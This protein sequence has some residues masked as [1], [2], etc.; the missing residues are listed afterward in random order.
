MGRRKRNGERRGYAS[1]AFGG[2]DAP[3]CYQFLSGE[4]SLY[5]LLTSCLGD[6]LAED[7]VI[8]GVLCSS[9]QSLLPRPLSVNEAP[10]GEYLQSASVSSWSRTNTTTGFFISPASGSAIVFYTRTIPTRRNAL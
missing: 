3:D 6:V 5:I 1:L 4:C 7:D 9:P 2:M 8:D 10:P